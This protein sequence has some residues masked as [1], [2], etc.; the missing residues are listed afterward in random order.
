MK[1]AYC[2]GAYGF[3]AFGLLLLFVLPANKY[4]WMEDFQAGV[5]PDPAGDSIALGTLLL[6]VLV[7]TQAVIVIMGKP[8][9]IKVWSAALILLAV[10]VWGKF[11]IAG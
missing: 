3:Y 9:W 6:L 8:M 11:V 1:K 2:V 5:P 7:A 4:S 10:L